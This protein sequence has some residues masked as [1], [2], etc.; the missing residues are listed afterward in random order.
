MGA[1]RN[2]SSERNYFLPFNGAVVSRGQGQRLLHVFSLQCSCAQPLVQLQLQ[3]FITEKEDYNLIFQPEHQK[4]EPQ[5]LENVPRRLLR[6]RKSEMLLHEVIYEFLGQPSCYTCV[7][8][9][10][11]KYQ[12]LRAELTDYISGPRLATR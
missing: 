8:L 1:N 7:E 6:Q 10:I 3:K 4:E 2:Q 9:I 12:T 11:F 5:G